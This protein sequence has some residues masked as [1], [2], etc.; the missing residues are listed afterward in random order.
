MW[1][2]LC[3]V[4]Y[5]FGLVIPPLFPESS[6]YIFTIH[7]KLRQASVLIMPLEEKHNIAYRNV[8]F[9][10]LEK[11]KELD[12]DKPRYKYLWEQQHQI[13]D[14]LKEAINKLIEEPLPA[15]IMVDRQKWFDE[16]IIAKERELV[17]IKREKDL[18]NQKKD[19]VRRSIDRLN[20]FMKKVGFCH[21]TDYNF[22]KVEVMDPEP[23]INKRDNFCYNCRVSID[24]M[25]CNE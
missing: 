15:E 7:N 14:A 6:S 1:L 13:E 22:T 18:I 3:G 9:E 19:E 4:L 2:K 10:M 21:F 11:R 17:S 8:F 24:R 12:A 20:N 5:N 25:Q 16:N 23:F